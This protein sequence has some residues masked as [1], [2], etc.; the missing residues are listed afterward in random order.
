[1][2]DPALREV[3]ERQF[4]ATLRHY[5]RF[6]CDKFAS[7]SGF[8][9]SRSVTIWNACAIAPEPSSEC[10]SYRTQHPCHL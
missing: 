10:S 5:S 8:S 4:R 7:L 6:F 1:M 3:P 9:V 2:V